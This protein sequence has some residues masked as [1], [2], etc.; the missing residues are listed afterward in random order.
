[1]NDAGDLD[2]ENYAQTF[3]LRIHV[4][5]ATSADIAFITVSVDDTND[6]T[7][8]YNANDADDD[9]T[10]AEN[11]GTGSFDAGTITDTDTGNSFTCTLGGDDAA[12]FDCDITDNTVDL[13]FKSSPDY[14]NAADT[15]G[16]NVYEFTVLINDGAANDGNGPTS[17]TVRVTDLNDQAPSWTTSNTASV[18][19]NSQTVAT[20]A[21]TDTD[22]ADSGGLAYAIQ[23]N[24]N[25]LFEIDGTT[26]QFATAPNYEAPGCGSSSNSCTVTV[27]ATDAAGATTDLT[28]T[29]TINDLNDQTP[30]WTTSNTASVNENSQTVATLAATDTDTADAGGLAYAIQTNDNDLFEIDGTTLQ[31]ATAPNYEAPGC[32]SPASNSCSVTVRA[33]DAA[34]A[35]ADLTITVTINDL[36]DQAPSW[37]TANTA[38]VNENSQTVVAALAATDTDT[39]DAGGLAYAIQTNDNDLFEIDGTTLQFAT[40]PNYEAPGC[41]SS[42]N[43]CTVTVRATDAAGATADLTI[44]VTVQDVNDQT[45]VYNANDA[46]DDITV[47]ENSGTGSFDAGTITDTDTGNSF[48]CTLGGDDA[49]LFDCDITDNTVDLSFKSSPDYDNAADTGGNNVYEFTVLINDGAA[50]DGNGP[51][52]V[53][54]RVTDLN[55]QTP[56]YNANDADDDITVAENSGT[57]SFDAGTITDSDT[58][59]SF[60]C[61]LGGDDAALFDCDITDNTVDLSF[62]SSPDYVNAAD[63]GGNNVYEFTVLI[64]DGAANDGNGPT[65]VT[66]RVTDLNDQAP[67]WTT[68]NTASVNENSQAVAT[69]AATD[70]DTAD[71]GGLAYAIQTND[72]DLFE[73]DG[74]TLQFATAPNYEA[75]GCGSSSNSCT[76]TVRATDAAGT[77]TDLTITV[78]IND[79]NDQTPSWTT[80]NTASVNENSQTVATLA[81]TDTDTADA[82]G[83][84]YAI[85]TNDNDLF[86]IDGTTLQFATAPNY[87]APGCGSPS[88]S[89]TVTVRATDA[90]GATA[91]LTITVTINDLNDQT[92]VYNAN[93]A[94]DDITVA[95]NS[96]TGS[97]DA[98]TITDTDTGNSFT[99]TLGGDDA[100]LFDCDI[101]DN[102]VDLSFKSSPDYDN[103]ADTGGNNVYEFTV[104]INDGAANDGNGPTSVTVR[105]TDLNDQAPSWTT[106]NTAS[107]NENSQTVATLAATDTDT[108]DSGGLAY[109]IQTNDNDLFEIDGTTLQFA[110]APDYDTP[111]CGNPASNSCT[112]TVRATDAAG[113]TTDL[114]IT[115]T[116]N[117]LNDQ[118]PSWTTSNTASVNENSQTV[119]AALA[120]TDTDT[121]DAGGLAYA[122]QTNDND[123]FEIDGTTL[124]FATAPN[125]EAPGC[126][127]SSNS[128]SV[129][130]R[131]TDAA[132]ATA[133]LTITV[134]INDLNDQAPSWTT[135]NTASVNE[136][137]QTVATLAA[138]DTD[139]ADA[140]GLAY[141]IQTNDNDLFEIDG[142]TL[143]FATAPNYEAPGCGN[144]ASNSCTVT[145]RA[146]DA[147]GATTDLTITVTVQ[148]VNDQT[149]VYNANDADDDITVAENSGT[150]SF[151]AGTITDTD[152]G[153][154]FTCTLGGDDAALFDCDITDN[155]VDLSFKSSPDYDNAADTGGNNVYEFTV[156]INDGAAN[157]GNGP[158]SVTVRVTDLNDQAPS[159]TTS[160]TASVNENTQTVATLA[161]TDTDTAD[162]GGLAY[163]ITSND[164]NLFSIVGGTT[165]RFTS[166][167]D[168]EAPGCGSSSNSCTVTV[169][170]TDAA[171]ATA[172]LTITVT[173]QDL[174]LVIA[175]GQSAT[176]NENAANGDAVMTVSQIGD[177]SGA[178]FWTINGGDPN[179]VF[180][181]NDDGELTVDSNTH[182]D[183]DS[184]TSYS[185]TIFVSDGVQQFDFET[186]IINVGDIN[187]QTPVYATADADSDITVAEN[188][189]TGSFDAGT[190]TDTDTGNVFTC[191][192]GGNDAALFNCDITDN[193][194]DLS[195]KA[196]PNYESPGDAGG[197]NVYDFTVLINDGVAN[198]ANGAKS[199]TVTVTDLNDQ[200]PVYNANDADDDITVAENSGTGSFDAGTITDSD[201]G[202]S[203]TCTLGGDDAALFDCD[204]TDNT[205]DLSFKSSP[206][207]DNAA[208]TGG[209]NV[210]EFTV[211]INDGAANDGNGPTSVTVRVTDLNDQAP[212]WTTS[213]T[214]S[215]NENSQTVATLAA[216]DTDSA[217][218]GGLAYAIQ[219]N[220]NDLFEIDG[221]TLQFATAP[222]YD[223]PGCG[224]P[225]SN[226]CTVTVRATDAAGTT[227]DLTITVTIN[228]LNDQAPSWTTSNT[229]SV[230]ENSQTVATLAA[231]DT[232]TADA[233][234]LAYAIQTNDN[235]L[236]EIDGTTLQFA[237]A[238][239]YE[240]PGC[241]NP[242]NSCTVTV[243]ATDAAGATTDL[244]ITVTINDLN[245]QTPSW[246]TSNTASVNENSQTVV[247]A[248]A[249]TDTDTADAGGLAYAIQTNDND[250]FEIDGT[251][252]QFAT[253]PNYEA[254]GCGSSSNSCTVTVRATDAAGATADLTI[255][256]TVQDVNDQTPVYNAN[257]ADDDI[258]VAENSGT[259]SFDAGTITD[260]D[261]GNSFTCTLGGDDAALFDCDITDNT[262][263]LSFKS[264]PDYDNAADTG[265]NNVYEFTVLINDGAANDGNGPTSV[266]VRVTDLNDQAP[267]WTTSNTASVNENSQTVATLAATD[268]DTADSGGLAYAIQTNDND[269]FE[270][271]GTTLQFA[272]APNYEAPGCGSSSNSCTVT[273]RATDAAGT[274]T[275][276][277]ITVTI[278]DLNDQTPSWTTSNTA[279]VNENS[280]TVATLAATDTDTADA[281]GLAYAIQTNDNDL[282]EIDG[283]TLQFATAPNYEAPGCGSSSNSC[284][285]TVRATD[286]AGATADLTIT[287]TINDL[288]DQTP[289]YNA[290]DAD[291][292]ITVAENSGTG[293]FDAGT[294]TDS[295][296]GNSFTC[297]LG[298]DDAALFDCDITDNTV[299]L[300]FKSSPDY[301]NAADTGGNNVYEFTVL[302]ND[303]AANDG[304]GPTSVTVRVTDLNDQA[305]S[306]TTSNTASVNENSQT[307]ATLAA[308]DTDTADSG[309]LAY[310]IQTNDNDLFEI[311]GTTL[312][313]ATAP[314]Y[315][316]PGCGSSSNSCTVTVRATD[317]A[318]TTTDL[319]ITVTINDLNDQTPSWTTSNTA[320]VNENSQTVATLAATDT[321]TADA[322]GLAY[323]IQTN[324]NDLF[325]IDGTTLQ[326]ATAPNYEAP[327]CGSSSNSCT[328]TVRATDAAGATADL[329]ITVTIN[330][331]NDQTPSWT[332]ANTASVNENSQTVA[333]LAATDTDTADAGG[334]AYAIQTNDNDLF[335]IDGTT[336]QFATAPDYDTPGCGSSS[337]SC[338]VTVRA[339]DAAGA[340]TDLTITVTIND[341]NDQAPSWTTSNTASVNEN[342]Q[343]VATL[344]AT[345]TDTADS[346][347]LAYAIQTNDNDLFEIDGTTLQF[348][349]APNYEA[350]GCGSSSNSCTVTVRATD[351]AGA[352]TDLTITVTINDLNDQT[353]VYNANDADDDI[354]VAENSG[355][356]SF[357]AGTITDSDTGNSFTC[358][359]GG[360]DAALFD[361][362]ITD[363]TVDLSFKSSPDYDN[364]ADTGGN[365]VYEFTVLIND[366]AANDGNGPTSVTVRVTDLNDQAP[367][368]TTSNTASV[369]E[370]SQTVATLAATDTDTADSGGLAYAIQT[371]DNDLFEIDGT[372]LQFAT[373]PNYEAPGCGSSSN[374]C[375]VTVRATDAAGT[376]TDLTITVTI[377]DLNDQ[378]PVYNANDADDDITVAEN[379]GTGSFDAGTITDS[380][381]GNSFT[382]TL[383]G[384]DA[385]LFD[386]DITDNT[387]DLS[388][389]SSPDYDNAADTGGNNV[390]EFTVLITTAPPTTATGRPPSPSG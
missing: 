385:A 214:A 328:V 181:I 170:A 136:N 60:T 179:G 8:V 231:T 383:G 195:F 335:E 225:A 192:L 380:D 127:S 211:L 112:V 61:T 386:C 289:V 9:I 352:T 53:T 261:T 325:E 110:T 190:I 259:G 317:A 308:T 183:Y 215:V 271:D 315:E 171:G 25:D 174:N 239:N 142:T 4:N 42:S 85:Q 235:D 93:D 238:P 151:D 92:P 338:T 83:L 70:T 82:G 188:S 162:S 272:T 63:T 54:V 198:D 157:D 353:P 285:V 79:L 374:S 164:N 389:K 116:I 141:A 254:P 33:T 336:L 1:M 176:L 177:S 279:S 159:W 234:G 97:F 312:Q 39:A 44:T 293:S 31:F 101:T 265:G 21:A 340:T 28:I 332:T 217:D 378:T 74:T 362:D 111:G 233:G 158:T 314:N 363:N 163:S 355:T 144:P 17:V 109:A 263:D 318:G 309:G 76:V 7:P 50:N 106:S 377:N 333:T 223:T 80:S 197:N 349:T 130:V 304:N 145:V 337:N 390:Y 41:G 67:S 379:S 128:C 236:F 118:T 284:T 55:D 306:W 282:F 246:T 62:K 59:N 274:T 372:T 114:T 65:S 369:N 182:L 351:A 326:F 213:N 19:E 224:N 117:D 275:D 258:T 64:N 371:N 313:F 232:D 307:V 227:T 387:V 89:C 219:T 244:T 216:T 153:N 339:T 147:A 5:D 12:L 345:D 124:Q 331:L 94:D 220:D 134:T 199:V 290:N 95:E 278:N 102:T 301:D 87:E 105:V 209:N 169:R 206:D 49:A 22:T 364:A 168:Y 373:A 327:G 319:T 320:S 205:V 269:L 126:G 237:T 375:T 185:L 149:P 96:G 255:T 46:D 321:D 344:A 98:G 120:A 166:A 148:D 245:D 6:Q 376:T 262:V 268:T 152:T 125:Y 251:T 310:A 311:D 299:D 300:S 341:L 359:L 57:G 167:P 201:T 388:F 135:A 24:D 281:G 266:T 133:D 194:V 250:L 343:T 210:Y 357:D 229:A 270:I 121:A 11:S 291:D 248:L 172:D 52:S 40:A 56:V 81:A 86:E 66:V 37:T 84:A 35:T 10:V 2:Y 202:N 155:T 47:A 165:L 3:T 294:I 161:A 193:T 150:G 249:A 298:G 346:G 13:S 252:L 36:N 305:P 20:L 366:G 370:N 123:L 200:T 23:T 178:T 34:G 140:G 180:A 288:N 58:G 18:N 107:V 303:G 186:V 187:D 277:T 45:P 78:T 267:S 253:A 75:P 350:P 243:R 240:A 26:L 295:D 222:D 51:T 316:A 354:T 208:D 99:C 286:A 297:T 14:D 173:I 360:D 115:V 119:V 347:G 103:A 207:Y 365:N 191:T 283:T 358:T 242:S 226:S 154:S 276:L 113:T 381:T 230:N 241:G 348:A 203:F 104:L 361:C 137:S 257:D 122:I 324:D 68:A 100:A 16:N 228:D 382:C 334:L 323:A 292:D 342:T 212:S 368:W 256:V 88:N 15:G 247:A 218:S 296:T 30:S 29:V 108:A 273:V 196:D 322:G 146:T 129:T 260:S 71:S 73:I 131:A 91:D 384:D 221:T 264:S 77:T 184:T 175:S 302:I 156:L 356:G 90:A 27:R 160:N 43:S 204:I 48:T 139:T 367:S 38:S 329:T 72:N 132:G 189:G 143:Q 330:D 69:L 138:T 287:V 280:Q 32:G